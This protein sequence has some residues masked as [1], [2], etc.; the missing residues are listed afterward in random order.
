MSLSLYR[1]FHSVSVKKGSVTVDERIVVH[2]HWRIRDF[3]FPF[4]PFHFSFPSSLI[5][6]SFLYPFQ[7]PFPSLPF[8]ELRMNCGTEHPADA[9]PIFFQI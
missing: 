2:N 4:L 5:A 1:Q 3:P 9:A 8:L 7:F 6:H